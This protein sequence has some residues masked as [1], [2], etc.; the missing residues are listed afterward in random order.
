MSVRIILVFLFIC[1][2]LQ[3]TLAQPDSVTIDGKIDKLTAR[4][5]RQA[6][7]LSVIRRNILETNEAIVYNIP[8]LA[9]G[10]FR[11]RIPVI[12]GQEECRFVYG[13]FIDTPLL[14]APRQSVKIT[15]QG[16]SITKKAIPFQFEGHLAAVN[17]MLAAYKV[18]ETKAFANNTKIIKD[19]P[20]LIAPL[21]AIKAYSTLTTIENEKIDVWNKFKQNK[22]PDTILNNWVLTNYNHETIA[23]LYDYLTGTGN[24]LPVELQDAV[25]P[26]L[27]KS[28]S[29]A[30]ANVFYKMANYATNQIKVKIN[31]KSS[32]PVTTMTK[33]LLKYVPLSVSE[34]TYLR[35]IIDS[36]AAKMSDLSKLNQFYKRK[37]DT[38]TQVLSYELMAQKYGDTYDK[39]TTEFLKAQ[40]SPSMASK[41]TYNE[42][43]LIHAHAQDD[44]QQSELKQSASEVYSRG[45]K[46]KPLAD[47][48]KQRFEEAPNADLLLT[49]SIDELPLTDFFKY[50]T[51]SGSNLLSLIKKSN[52]GKMLY[53]IPWRIG[54]DDDARE[55]YYA[56]QWSETLDPSKI[57]FVYVC[58][59][60]EDEEL[61]AEAATRTRTR[62]LH[63]YLN[64]IQY[65]SFVSSFEGNFPDECSFLDEKGNYK[66]FANIPWPSQYDATRKFFASK[67]L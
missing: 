49:Y 45:I 36:N 2:S 16:D 65:S 58:Q 31:N 8:L 11:G 67:G 64:S 54:N 40:F 28:L 56:R 35:A 43:T 55:L 13:N 9:D 17:N 34:R 25:T 61:W 18:F 37:N 20:R 63:L 27:G 53:F 59:W 26:K 46:D 29:F 38:L 51:V 6:S 32:L 62:G 33:L 10:S 12:F 1:G 66:R 19:I 5:Y 15:I 47:K 48:L 44:T 50:R 41:L 4:L 42:R 30:Q 24:T 23:E 21:Q 14:V 60:G 39:A 3:T 22:N 7:E 52:P 57:L